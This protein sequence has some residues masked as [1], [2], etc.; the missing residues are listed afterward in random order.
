MHPSWWVS[1][2]QS[3]K[4]GTFWNLNLLASSRPLAAEPLCTSSLGPFEIQMIP[5]LDSKVRRT[6]RDEQTATNHIGYLSH[7]PHVYFTCNS[8]NHPL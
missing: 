6:E 8:L 7:A 2:G 5:T 4:K 1:L 3:M